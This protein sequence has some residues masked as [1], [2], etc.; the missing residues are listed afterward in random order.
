VH[1][2]AFNAALIESTE[3][4]HSKLITLVHYAISCDCLFI[5]AC[6]CECEYD[7]YMT[8]ICLGKI[9]P[10]CTLSVRTRCGYY[11]VS[12]KEGRFFAGS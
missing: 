7:M 6:T 8:L 2:S 10:D 3:C 4:T 1:R 5:S 12:F 11:T 9:Q